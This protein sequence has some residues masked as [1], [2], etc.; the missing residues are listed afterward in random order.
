MSNLLS[1][2]DRL[3]EHHEKLCRASLVADTVILVMSLALLG[4][5]AWNLV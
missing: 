4:L 2:I 5:V 3:V 1:S